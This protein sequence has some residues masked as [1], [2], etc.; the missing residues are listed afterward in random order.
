MISVGYPALSTRISCAVMSDVYCVAVGFYVKGAVGRELQQVQ[1][2]QV[3][4]GIVQEHVLASTGCDAL[5][6]AV[7]LLVCQRLTVVSYC[8]PGSPQ[9]QVA[10]EILVISSF[11]LIGVDDA[12]VDDGAGGEIGVA[13]YGDHEVVGYADGV[14][15]VLEEDGAVGVGVGMRAV[16]ALGD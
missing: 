16:V 12:A 2:G 10:S 15:R 4:G 13:H 14:I 5:M 9:C 7:F 11:A 3:A 1:A 8:M 6:R